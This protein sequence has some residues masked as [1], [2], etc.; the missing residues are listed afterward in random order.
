MDKQYRETLDL[1]WADGWDDLPEAPALV[2]RPKKTQMTL[3]L[4][5]M[6]VN[7]I[8]RVAGIQTIPHHTLMRSWL[9]SGLQ[10][11]DLPPAV[12]SPEE[13]TQ[14]A[15]INLK[16]DQALLDSLKSRAHEQGMPYHRLA[17][18]LVESQVETTEVALGLEPLQQRAGLKEIVISLLHTPNTRGE[19]AIRGVTRLQKLLFV[20]EQSLGENQG[21]AAYNF[22]PFNDQVRDVVQSLEI[23]GFIGDEA[24]S[25]GP[26]FDSMYASVM[27]RSDNNDASPKEFALT[28]KGNEVAATLK[29]SSSEMAQLFDLVERIRDEWDVPVLNDLIDRVYAEWPEYTEKSLIK[30]EVETRNLGKR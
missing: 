10:V 20:V 1:D 14:S 15:Q 25:E 21:F 23:A 9:A 27:A 18:D 26:T 8:K 7:R 16:L 22:G 13:G 30:D 5:P 11:G 6:L 24:T 2:A 28:A 19:A 3:R 29:A 4:P 17:R 12:Q